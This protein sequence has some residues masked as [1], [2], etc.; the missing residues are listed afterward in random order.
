MDEEEDMLT[1]Q[2]LQD[3]ATKLMHAIPTPKKGGR[4]LQYLVA[5]VT[6]FIE[7]SFIAYTQHRELAIRT[8]REP[9]VLAVVGGV[10]KA[11]RTLGITVHDEPAPVA[12]HQSNGAAED[13]V[14]Q[15]RSR[16]GLSVQ[17]IED[18]VAAGRI[19]FGC[20]HP[21]S[22]LGNADG[23]FVT[24]SIRLDRLG[25]LE[26]WSWE[27]GYAALGNRPV[28]NKRVTQPFAFGVHQI[29]LEAV[30]VQRYALEHP[31]E[32][33]EP[34]DP[35][36]LVPPEDVA[37]GSCCMLLQTMAKSDLMMM[38]PQRLQYVPDLL[39]AIRARFA[40][41]A[42][43]AMDAMFLVDD[44]PAGEQAPKTPKLDDEA[45]K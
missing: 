26:S 4:Y 43:S 38:L 1:F 22:T 36:L 15:L 29:D 31:E 40:D 34:P 9:S 30:H 10:Q 17:Q 42:F 35:G 18:K 3:R 23:V 14:Q 44:T 28:Y 32:D 24:C 6:K 45:K 16:A 12:D 25:D 20:N 13:T 11:C 7:V 19:I 2:F 41:A 33:I 27:F 8:D 21:T 5:E 39:I 37:T